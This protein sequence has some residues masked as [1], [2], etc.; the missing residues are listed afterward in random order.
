M[1]NP[2]NNKFNYSTILDARDKFLQGENITNFLK[3]KFNLTSNTSEIIELSYELQAGSYIINYV[4]DPKP[5]DRY[6]NEMMEIIDGQLLKNYTVL[7]VGCGELTTLSLLLNNLKI[8]PKKLY[9]LDLS[10]SRIYKGL[11]FAKSKL[12]A[13]DYKKIIPIISD[14]S[15]IPF[16]DKTI[17]LI[18]LILMN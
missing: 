9:A 12:S 13:T 10:W 1:N 18:I 4:K 6:V 15:E 11:S 5:L 17:D 14:I 3:K 2:Y 8:K 16:A 7:D